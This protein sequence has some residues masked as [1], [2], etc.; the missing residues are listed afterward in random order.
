MVASAK[1]FVRISDMDKKFVIAELDLLASRLASLRDALAATE[2]TTPPPAREKVEK[3]L[4]LYC[5]KPLGQKKPTR[6]VHS[7]CYRT[8]RRRI[9]DGL[10]TD[11]TLVSQ[12]WLLP[13][14]KQGR[15]IADSDPVI[16]E[17]RA[18]AEKDAAEVSQLSKTRQSKNQKK[19]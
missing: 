9:A 17:L 10:T 8:A 14:E 6:G 4:C 3:G 12:G 7:H 5:G 13:Q 18:R 16:Q 1:N 15:K 11:A 2:P 19:P